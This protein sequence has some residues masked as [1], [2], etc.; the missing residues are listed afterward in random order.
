MVDAGDDDF[1]IG[2]D[3]HR[4]EARGVVFSVESKFDK[5]VAG[6]GGIELAVGEEAGQTQTFAKAGGEDPAI[7]LESERFE[8]FDIGGAGD[9]RYAIVSEVRIELA[10]REESARFERF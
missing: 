1:P 8:I 9:D 10:T 4:E 7:G 6:E 3:A 5:A 2:G